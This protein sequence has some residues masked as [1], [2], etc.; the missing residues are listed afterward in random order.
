M[1]KFQKIKG[2]QDFLPTDTSKWQY[3]EKTLIDTAELYG[4]KEIRVP[5]LE[6]TEVFTGAVG[7][8]SDV[9]QKEMY[10]L[11]DKGDRSLT[12][13]PEMTAG[14]VR[15]VIE[16]GL[17]NESL[18]LKLCYIG[19]CFR[20]E[21][22]Q[23]GRFRQFHQFGIE[24]FGS[25]DPSSDAE[26]IALAQDV[27]RMVG[28]ENVK[29]V[30]NSI[31]C[32]D[33]R[34]KYLEELKKYF[35]EYKDQLDGD[36]LK[37]IDL[38][39]MRILDSKVPTTQE[40]VKNAPKPADYLCDDCKNHFD[41]VKNYLSYLNIDYKVDENLVRGLDYYTNTVFELISGEIGSQSA[42][43]GG[44]R[45][46]PLVKRMGGKD[47]PALGFAMGIER[48]IMAMDSADAEIPEERKCEI[49]FASVGDI[50]SKKA[51]ELAHKL[52][53]E[54]FYAEYDNMGRG[55]KAQMRY[56]N[57][58]GA[59]YTIVLGEDELIKGVGKIRNMKTGKETELPLN[60]VLV[61]FL[62]NVQLSDAMEELGES[63]D[64]IGFTN[65][66]LSVVS[67]FVKENKDLDKKEFL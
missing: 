8:T 44:G 19:P 11:I 10:T 13:R 9:V 41:G 42:V 32:P 40:I 12:L 52:R 17:L 26:V 30:I 45:Y 28:I 23:A 67:E 14:V 60:D 46:N 38:N 20:Q 36:S 55:L 27:L 35:Y 43:A 34:P 16:N 7:E 33:C 3:V 15:S 6:Q 24:S 18:P 49:Y 2:M 53:E 57:K 48:L 56:A 59:H 4:F 51:F 25:N 66:D 29:L 1:G 63:V 61:D 50:A 22:P 47:T 31:G 65:V 64:E 39:P 5:I 58:I 37:R 62:Y 54:G 21:K